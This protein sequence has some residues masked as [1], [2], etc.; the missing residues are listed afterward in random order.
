MKI[1]EICSNELEDDEIE[2]YELEISK[3]NGVKEALTDPLVAAICKE[4]SKDETN[5]FKLFYEKYKVDILEQPDF[6]YVIWYEDEKKGLVKNETGEW[7]FSSNEAFKIAN[8]IAKKSGENVLVQKG[9]KVWKV[10]PKGV[11]KEN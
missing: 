6:V 7:W 11:V 4:C 10:G 9:Y 2:E 1:C 5:V 8:E 3:K